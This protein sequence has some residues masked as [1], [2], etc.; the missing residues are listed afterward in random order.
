MEY[1]WKGDFN[2]ENKKTGKGKEYD[3]DDNVI[4]E[5]EYS[6]GLRIKGVEYYIKG[7]K[8]YEGD[9]KDNKRWNGI[10]YDITM[11]HKYELKSGNG[12]I[13]QYYENGCL[14]FEGEIKNGEKT[15]KG[16]IYDESELLIFE[17]ILKMELNKEKEKF[18]IQ[19]VI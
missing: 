10:L 2:E 1:I 18:I 14:F 8:I 4:F 16:K 15:G 11:E 7:T 17:G 12:F 5:G 9:Y 13:K 19:V 6:N 3:F